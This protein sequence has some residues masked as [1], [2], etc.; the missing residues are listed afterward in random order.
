MVASAVTAAAAADVVI[1]VGGLNPRLEGEEMPVNYIGFGGGDRSDIALPDVQVELLKALHAT[2]K[3]VVFVNCSGS[4]VA[5]VWA[6]ENL[7]AILQAWYPGGEGG[8]A[9]A[10]ALFGES[11]PAGRLPVTFYRSTADLPAFD[12]YSM[13]NRTYRYFT[14]T[15]LFAFGHGLSYTKFKYSGAKLDHNMAGAKDSITV[16][17]KVKNTGK[18]DGD[19][20]AQVYFR[21]IHSIVAQPRLALCGFTRVHIPHGKTVPVSVTIPVERFRYWDTSTKSYEVEPGAYEIL[22]GGASDQLSAKLALEVR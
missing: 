17:V 22:V 1:Y 18:L 2:G 20:V 21:H 16:T 9:V 7:P 6:S 14:G 3:P 8:Q 5:M 13:S 15:P 19:E 11:N 12:D 10:E 4:A